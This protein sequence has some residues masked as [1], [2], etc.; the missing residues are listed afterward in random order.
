[1]WKTCVWNRITCICEN[2]KYLLSITDDSAFTIQYSYLI[3]YEAKKAIYYHF[4]TLIRKLILKT[5][6]VII[7]MIQLM[8]QKLILVTFCQTKNYNVL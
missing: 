4:M 2:G 5:V 8:V 6:C 1:M 3:K 7:L